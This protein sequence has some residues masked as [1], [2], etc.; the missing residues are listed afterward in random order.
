[1]TNSWPN[2]TNPHDPNR[3]PGGSSCGSAAA[4]ADFQ[5]PVALGAQTGG[6][7]IRPA[8]FT[9]VFALKPTHN[10]VSSEG[11]KVFSYTF[12]TIGFLT[13]SVHDLQ[14]LADVFALKDDEPVQDIPLQEASVALIKTPMWG[15]A[16]PGTIAAM[17]KAENILRNEGV[18]VEDVS[19]PAPLDDGDGLKRLHRVIISAEAQVSFLNEYQFDK[20]GLDPEIQRLVE[21][22]ANF[23]HRETLQALDTL[24]SMRSL[25]DDLAAKFSAIL[26]PSVIDEAP[27]GLGGIGSAAF[28]TLW[29]VSALSIR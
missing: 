4:V 28:N 10:A 6:S 11:T 1:V 19:F 25:V 22:S 16:G 26:T 14:L 3:T 15:R 29:T 9:G 8:S 13:R 17:E 18:R 21:N 23:T 5:V 27:L 2:T 7:I 20:G 12:D 24:A